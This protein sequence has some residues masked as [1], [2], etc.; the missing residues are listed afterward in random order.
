GVGWGPALNNQYRADTP[1]GSPDIQFYIYR[2][3]PG[4]D[5]QRIGES[6]LKRFWDS[7]QSDYQHL[8]LNAHDQYQTSHN[9]ARQSFSSTNGIN[10]GTGERFD[11]SDMGTLTDDGVWTTRTR[12]YSGP[13]ENLLRVDPNDVDPTNT[14][15]NPPGTRWFLAANEFVIGDEDVTNNSRWT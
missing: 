14:D 13:F 10:P 4:E 2:L 8:T 11:L 6:G 12:F 3:R 1:I 7:S 15:I 9:S 5:N